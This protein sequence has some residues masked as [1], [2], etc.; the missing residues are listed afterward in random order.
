[1]LDT[2][3]RMH[4]RLLEISNSEFYNGKI[5]NGYKILPKNAFL[6]PD[7]AP[8]LFINHET[9]EKDFGNSFCNAGETNIVAE[10][11]Q[12]FIKNVKKHQ[13]Q[14][15]GFVSP[16]QGQVQKLKSTLQPFNIE[17]NIRSI[18][19]WQGREKEI[20]IFSAVRCNKQRRIGFLEKPQRINVALTRAKHGLIIIGNKHTLSSDK[21]WASIIQ[22]FEDYECYCPSLKDAIKRINALTGTTMA[23]K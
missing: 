12:H 14:D 9:N 11:L 23:K 2:Q 7:E 18:D 20:V 16:Y 3:Y 21:T 17:D 15:F 1:M 8:M 10:L 6:N 5:Q 22:Y 13:I 4:P 19:S